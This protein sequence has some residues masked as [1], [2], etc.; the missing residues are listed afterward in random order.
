MP[1]GKIG[2]RTVIE[3]GVGLGFAQLDHARN[4]VWILVHAI[5]LRLLNR[6][7]SF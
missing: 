6:A 4:A 3:I 7:W 1:G 5:T 2:R